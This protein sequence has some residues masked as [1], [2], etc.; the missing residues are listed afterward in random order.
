M[1]IMSSNSG[2]LVLGYSRNRCT[3]F[4]FLFSW[5]HEQFKSE[6]QILNEQIKPLRTCFDGWICPLLKLIIGCF[7]TEKF[8]IC[9][10]QF[11]NE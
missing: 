5:D 7:I 8:K 3:L 2:C 1:S 4:N 10:K 9:P 6:H 11:E